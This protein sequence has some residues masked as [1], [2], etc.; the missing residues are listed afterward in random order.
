MPL[1]VAVPRSQFAQ[2]LNV[3]QCQP[4][5]PPAP[6]PLAG[7]GRPV[8]RPSQSIPASRAIPLATASKSSFTSQLVTRTHGILPAA[9][10]ITTCV[11]CLLVVVTHPVK[12]DD[13]MHSRQQKSTMYCQSPP[14][15]ET[16]ALQPSPT[17]HRPK[18]SAPAAWPYDEPAGVVKHHR[19]LGRGFSAI[20][21]PS[22]ANRP[23]PRPLS[24]L[25]ERGDVAT[26]PTTSGDR[27]SPACSCARPG[28]SSGGPPAARRRCSRS[29]CRPTA[30]SCG[31]EHLVPR[32][33]AEVDHHRGL[34]AELAHAG[35]SLA[36]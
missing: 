6:L 16:S 32:L 27:R 14:A 31:D 9:A 15:V 36:R 7:E 29:R 19:M 21:H 26:H 25:R 12:F 11:G 1:I 34:N 18:Q 8:R 4:P 24:R 2:R 17:Q 22:A 23:H 10:I 35:R 28:R 20:A 13:Q 30:A 33:L 3:S 5:S